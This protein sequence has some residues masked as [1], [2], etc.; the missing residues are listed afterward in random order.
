MEVLAVWFGCAKYLLGQK[1]GKIL[2]DWKDCWWSFGFV[3]WLENIGWLLWPRLAWETNIPDFNTRLVF[4]STVAKLLLCL[5]KG[6][7]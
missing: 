7:D 3:F 2:Y 6:K 4:R 5:L 1:Q